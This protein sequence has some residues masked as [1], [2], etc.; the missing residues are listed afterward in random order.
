MKIRFWP[1]ICWKTCEV[2]KV[3]R[4]GCGS[5]RGRSP[6]RRWASSRR[7]CRPSSA[8]WATSSPGV[9]L[10]GVHATVAVGIVGARA[11]GGPGGRT[12]RR[13]RRSR[14]AGTGP[15]RSARPRGRSRCPGGL[16]AGSAVRSRPAALVVDASVPARRPRSEGAPPASHA[17]IVRSS[18]P[19][20]RRRRRSRSPWRRSRTGRAS[21]SSRQLHG[22][23]DAARL[24]VAEVVGGAVVVEGTLHVELDQGVAGRAGEQVGGVDLELVAA[25]DRLP[26]SQTCGRSPSSPFG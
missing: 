14:S 24:V 4:A 16:V 23:G 20:A 7:R 19:C 21:S 17:P 3:P 18:V 8:S 26:P 12:R 6:S 13:A 10:V 15:T 2:Q 1:G 25:E 5:G 11:A 22:R 9:E